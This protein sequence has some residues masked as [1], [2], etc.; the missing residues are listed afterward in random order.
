MADY[1]TPPWAQLVAGKP[2]TDEKAAAAFE[3]PIAIAEG[4]PDAPRLRVGALQR[5]A[6]GNV[7]RVRYDAIV[8]AEAGKAAR[9]L[10]ICFS[11]NGSVRVTWQDK[12]QS[13]TGT[14][15][16]VRR[17]YGVETTIATYTS[18]SSWSDRTVDVAVSTGDFIE[19]RCVVGSVQAYLQLLR[20]QTDG[21]DI[22]PGTEGM[23]P[24]VDGSV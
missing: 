10:G 16:L 4:A 24:S 7:V 1:T 6:P 15:T 20:V 3:N 13:G 8:T 14:A 11:Q 9:G 23:S 21:A 5:L 2:W 18:T 12:V 19:V 17:R 22:W